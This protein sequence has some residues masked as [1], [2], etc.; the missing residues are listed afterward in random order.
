VVEASGRVVLLGAEGAVGTGL[1]KL[2]RSWGIETLSV[3]LPSQASGPRGDGPRLAFEVAKS[4]LDELAVKHLQRGDIAVDLVPTLDKLDTVK[5][6]SLHGVSVIN[7]T[8]ISGGGATSEFVDC[9]QDPWRKKMR[10]LPVPHLLNCGANP[11]NVNMAVASMRPSPTAKVT[12]WE[13]DGTTCETKPTP[14]TT[15]SGRWKEF[16]TEFTDEATW[17]AMWKDGKLCLE[18]PGGPP[19]E[20]ITTIEVPTVGTIRGGLC[21]HEELLSVAN[22]W[23]CSCDYVYGWEDENLDAMMA[24]A[25]AQAQDQA[26]PPKIKHVLKGRD[27]L[28]GRDVVG[29]RVVDGGKTRWWSHEIAN[30][31]PRVPDDS[32]ATAYLVAAS[33]AVGVSLMLEGRVPSGAWFPE[34]TDVAL[35]LDRLGALC[36]VK[37]DE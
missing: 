3:D 33:I 14:F 17:V 20:N 19:V 11:G 23:H 27:V 22:Q 12:I 30:E 13:Q 29:V 2:L 18:Y 31:D 28:G 15:W 10:S 36:E 16:W 34:E 21:E 1:R 7:T 35:W 9:L 24:V 32:T 25:K 8:C 37:A 5:K 26:E 6:L 4:T